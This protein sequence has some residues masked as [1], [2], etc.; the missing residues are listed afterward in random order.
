MISN[1]EADNYKNINTLTCYV[2]IKPLVSINNKFYNSSLL[3]WTTTPWTL[4]CNVV[5][6]VNPDKIYVKVL[7]LENHLV[8]NQIIN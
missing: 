4:P 8:K 3:V 6:C 5:L 7:Y 1:S 2:K